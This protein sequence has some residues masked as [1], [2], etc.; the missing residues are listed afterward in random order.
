[1][2]CIRPAR[3]VA[4][5]VCEILWIKRLLE[6][7]LTIQ[8][9]GKKYYC[10]EKVFSGFDMEELDWLMEHL[11]KAVEREV[12]ENYRIRYKKE[13]SSS[14]R[15]EGVKGK[16]WEDLRKAI[17]SVQEYYERDGGASKERMVI[18]G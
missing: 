4:H 6:E 13:T 1:M 14:C 3:V 18:S 10:G 7:E 15:P 16:G 9:N 5:A 12:H 17:L 2:E 11:K 8:Q